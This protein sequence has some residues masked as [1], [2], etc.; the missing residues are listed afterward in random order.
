MNNLEPFKPEN[1]LILIVDD[2]PKNLQ[3][4]IE[5]LDTSGYGTT[6]A[7]SGEQ[8]LERVEVTD[9]D[10]ILLDLMM[11]KMNGIEVCKRLKNNP[12]TEQIPII[13]L[14][15]A[16]ETNYLISAFEA[17]AVDY[18]TKPFKTPELL[19]RIKTHLD[20]KRTKDELI[21]AYKEMQQIAATDE[22]TGIANRRSIF[23]IGK[24]EFERSQRYKSP[25]SI[26]MIDI[27]KFKSINDTYGHDVGDEA[28]KM[29]VKITLNCLRKV[30]H[31]GR[32]ETEEEALAKKGHL[33]RLG[34]EEFV[35]ILPHTNLKGAYKA[36]QRVCEAMPQETLQVED[37]TVSITVSIGIGTYD[38]KDQKIDDILK[39]AD[40][41]L[42]A[43]KKNGRNR[44]AIMHEEQ[45]KV[46][47]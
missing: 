2:I 21:K 1:F 6:F 37:K 13:F 22:L 14:T 15:A 35:V 43:A 31:I 32:L 39:R 19:A 26:L 25:F 16:T 33:G 17:G 40:L 11:P 46:S 45:L 36:A 44:V 27:D 41:A 20:L 8:A 34:G 24:Q 29:M 23:N 30:D 3:L 9:P 12:K 10:L 4:L 18:V 38:P 7:V 28:L 42:F 47:Q 5:I